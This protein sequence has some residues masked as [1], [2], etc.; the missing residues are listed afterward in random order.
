MYDS[1]E[2][3]NQFLRI[4]LLVIA[5]LCAII[6]MGTVGKIIADSRKETSVFRAVG[7]KRLDIAQVY[8]LYAGTLAALAFLVSLVLGLAAA[9]LVNAKFSGDLS[10]QAVL[11]FN[12][13]DVNKVFHLIGFNA[14]DLVGIFAFAVATGL[15]SAFIPLLTNLRRNP[16]KDMREE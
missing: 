16:I 2:G 3:F 12:S 10:V 4:L 13:P 11:A 7:A 15:I 14:L 6:M 8:L 1:Q 9:L 5:G